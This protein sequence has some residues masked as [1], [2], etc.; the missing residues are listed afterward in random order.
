MEFFEKSQR[1]RGSRA[2]TLLELLVVIGIIALLASLLLPA[3]GK[4]TEKARQTQCLNH[5]RQAG[6]AMQSFAHDHQDRFPMQVPA[7]EGGSAEAAR[8]VLPANANLSFSEKHFAALSNELGSSRVFVCPSD[9]AVQVAA[10]AQLRKTNISYWVNARANPGDSR[11]ILV[12]DRN[13]AAGTNSGRVKEITSEIAFTRSLHGGRGNIG[14]AD[15]HVDQRRSFMYAEI[16]GAAPVQLSTSP[17]A[18][19]GLARQEPPGRVATPGQAAP[20]LQGMPP[21]PPSGSRG[22]ENV[23]TSALIA[24][25]DRISTSQSNS[26]TVAET[27][28]PVL[29]SASAGSR[30]ISAIE[31]A[32]T[33]SALNLHPGTVE[34]PLPMTSTDRA[35]EIPLML[36][37][38]AAGGFLVLLLLLVLLARGIQS[39]RNRTRRRKAALALS[40]SAV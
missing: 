38:R 22:L 1:R 21:Q 17:A 34:P 2:F 7:R 27:V 31:G 10:F 40:R 13:I 39:V 36:A 4:A 6:L 24:S 30:R 9:R 29:P 35:E 32:N 33:P 11:Q 25:T 5:L 20:V 37:V 19:P 14:F 8:E 12:G 18:A 15:G 26:L 28:W 3:I 16:F 23:T